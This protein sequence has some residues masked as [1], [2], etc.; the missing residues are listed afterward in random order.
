MPPTREEFE[1]LKKDIQALND[2][3]YRNNFSGRQDFVKFS[4]FKTRLK[5]PHYATLPTTCEV[6]EIA[7]QGGELN[8]CS[9]ANTWTVVGTQT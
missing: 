7:E 2:E 9:A 6:G 1:Q 3:F 8:I 5:V 4:D